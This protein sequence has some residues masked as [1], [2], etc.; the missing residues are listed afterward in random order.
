MDE[1]RTKVNEVLSFNKSPTPGQLTSVVE[2]LNDL[3][4]AYHADDPDHIAEE[5]IDQDIPLAHGPWGHGCFTFSAPS[6]LGRNR[7]GKGTKLQGF[8]MFSLTLH[9]SQKKL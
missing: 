3:Y 6:P 8:S 2:R 7:R 9:T 5:A 4:T 1:V